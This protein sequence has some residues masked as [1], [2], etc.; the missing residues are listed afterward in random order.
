[1]RKI[2]NLGRAGLLCMIGGSADAIGYLKF[3]TFVGAMTGNTVLLGIEL[4]RWQLADILFHAFIVGSFFLATV[5]GR[6]VILAR[7]P[8]GAAFI[9]NAILLATS[10][11]IESKWGVALSAAALGLQNAVVR[12]IGGVS[13]N[14]VYITGNLVRLGSAFPQAGRERREEI[15]LLALAWTAYAAGAV[16]GAFALHLTAYAMTVPALLS[17]FAAIMESW[18]AGDRSSD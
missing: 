18:V 8:D 12:K 14:T 11:L 10:A 13:V 2:V 6:L 16:A 4:A 17:L 3:E 15:V 7:L 1:M 9:V 5:I